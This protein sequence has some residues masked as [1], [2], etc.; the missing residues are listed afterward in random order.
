M[1]FSKTHLANMTSKQNDLAVSPSAVTG[2]RRLS[3][4][5]ATKEEV[6]TRG[7]VVA[8]PPRF[9]TGQRAQSSS[10][11]FAASLEQARE[12]LKPSTLK[13]NRLLLLL[14]LLQQHAA[15]RLP[16]QT[17]HRRLVCVAF[18]IGGVLIR[19]GNPISEAIEAMKVLN[20]ENELGV[21]I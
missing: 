9:M 2:L 10:R 8:I 11:G 13:E 18:D 1:M 16:Q 15:H 21:R 5:A 4:M 7:P 17:F 20:G 19:G 6:S 3:S 14:L 12:E